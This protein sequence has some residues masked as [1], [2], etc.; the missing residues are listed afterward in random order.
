MMNKKLIFVAMGV[1]FIPNAALPQD[2]TS[3]IGGNQSVTAEDV[4]QAQQDL[5]RAQFLR[6]ERSNPRNEN[7]IPITEDELAVNSLIKLWEFISEPPP[8][9]NTDI[10]TSMVSK[11]VTSLSDSEID[12]IQ[13]ELGSA[14]ELAA[15]SIK[16]NTDALCVEWDSTKNVN[17]NAIG[18]SIAE[19]K[20]DRDVTQPLVIDRFKTSLEKIGE[21]LDQEKEDALYAALTEIYA[22][23]ARGTWSR[24]VDRISDPNGGPQMLRS[25]CA[26]KN[27][28]VVN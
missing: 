25:L 7:S 22:R 21:T 23:Y 16:S 12:F 17:A 18:L 27:L 28:N 11:F 20:K 14:F 24:F 8:S 4:I 13:S 3:S 5:N 6:S 26:S 9:S 1:F 15:D 19:Y 2:S 10:D